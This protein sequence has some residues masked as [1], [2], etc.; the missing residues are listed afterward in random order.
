MNLMTPLR[1]KIVA[2]YVL[3]AMT[4]AFLWQDLTN[5]WTLVMTF[6]TPI[7]AFFIALLTLEIGVVIT[8]LGTVLILFVKSAVGLLIAVSKVGV[9]KGLFLPWLLSGLQW[10]HQK[11][12]FLQK[13]VH[14]LF[15]K[16]RAIANNMYSW[17]KA[18]H[19][20]DKFL[21][22]GFLGPLILIVSFVIVVKRFVYIFLSR[23]AA[24]QV[25]Q[26]ATKF[27]VNSFYKAPV[28]MKMPAR[29]KKKT[30]NL[31]ASR[32]SR[33]DSDGEDV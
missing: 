3:F 12:E 17:W 29:L 2:G 32:E 11:S 9:I 19:L 15:T 27:T 16:G 30:M 5:G 1:W 21:L 28:A 24:E 8:A 25:V 26:K 6:L 23:K 33:S 13:W 20:L 7:S 22:L 4:T 10:L 14:K 18:Q 31:T